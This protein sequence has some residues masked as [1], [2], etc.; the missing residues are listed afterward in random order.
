MY[1]V[2]NSECLIYI[3]G[4]ENYQDY[5][6]SYIPASFRGTETSLELIT[7]KSGWFVKGVTLMDNKHF[8]TRRKPRST[9][10]KCKTLIL[11]L[12]LKFELTLTMEQATFAVGLLEMF[13]NIIALFILNWLNK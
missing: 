5:E 1:Y 4:T 13:Y 11:A 8:H 10:C 3:L 9:D 6:A 12:K 7:P 2:M